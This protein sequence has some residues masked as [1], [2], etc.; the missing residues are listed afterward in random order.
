MIGN[1][2]ID[3]LKANAES[4]WK[5]KGFLEKI[6]TTEEQKMINDSENP[7]QMIWRLWSMKESVYK[8]V[9]RETLNRFYT[10][11]KFICN[12]EGS[13]GTVTIEGKIFK[14]ESDIRPNLIH[15]IATMPQEALNQVKTIFLPNAN[16]Y[17]TQ[18]NSNSKDFILQK[19]AN[20][21][22]FMVSRLNQ[23]KH[24]S[25]ISHHG[26]YLALIYLMNDRD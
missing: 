3:L 18:F 14:T 9:N 20:G 19:D 10:P 16:D 11:T 13:Q 4:N 1:D 5:R 7:E 15:T 2:I 21:L 23:R 6:F 22:P 26:S 8:I 25:S 24:I 17:L 12:I